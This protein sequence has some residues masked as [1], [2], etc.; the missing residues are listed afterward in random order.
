MTIL[1]VYSLVKKIIT[2]VITI[3]DI[4]KIIL[5]VVRCFKKH[6]N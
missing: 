6:K 1:D 3:K 2:I 5:K 4:I